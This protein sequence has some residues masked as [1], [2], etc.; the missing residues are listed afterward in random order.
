MPRDPTYRTK[1]GYE[2]KRDYDEGYEDGYEDGYLD[3]KQERRRTSRVRSDRM[4]IPK[5]RRRPQ[6]P[7]KKRTTLSAW[8]KFVKAN[9]KKKEFRIRGKKLNFKKLGIA[10][11]KKTGKRKGKK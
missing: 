10:Y 3:A 2:F 11:R 8:Q 4:G 6:K 5:R 7:K 9:S 1:Y